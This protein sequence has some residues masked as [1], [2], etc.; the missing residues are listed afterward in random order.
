MIKISE[1]LLSSN[2][3]HKIIEKSLCKNPLDGNDNIAKIK[4]NNNKKIQFDLLYLYFYKVDKKL[5]PIKDF[6]LLLHIELKIFYIFFITLELNITQSGITYRDTNIVNFDNTINILNIDDILSIIR[7]YEKYD[8]RVF[9]VGYDINIDRENI[10]YN[11]VFLHNISGIPHQ[12]IMDH[13]KLN[14]QSVFNIIFLVDTMNQKHTIEINNFSLMLNRFKFKFNRKKFIKFLKYKFWN[15]CKGKVYH[16]IFE[17]FLMNEREYLNLYTQYYNSPYSIGQRDQLKRYI[18][19][20]ESRNNTIQRLLFWIHEG[21]W[22]IFKPLCIMLLFILADALLCYFYGYIEI[23][24]E[25]SFIP[26]YF[27]FG[28]YIVYKLLNEAELIKNYY[29][30]AWAIL[31]IY[32]TNLT[33][34]LGT[35]YTAWLA[36]I[37][38]KKR[39]FG[40]KIPKPINN[41]NQNT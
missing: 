30:P 22:N 7:G 19:F 37:G 21:H 1:K 9:D 27:P 3:I 14:N 13:L 23:I 17:N 28:D 12:N 32:I 24:K 11:N 25:S 15:S 20:F 26:I 31:I 4:I 33:F 18:E 36:I 29:H 10:V 6:L 5:T 35:I 34:K 40:N 2:Y 39:F 38:I 8:N 16:T 41:E